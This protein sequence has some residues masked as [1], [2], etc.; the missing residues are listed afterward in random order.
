MS[1]PTI[2]WLTCGVRRQLEAYAQAEG[3]PVE[4]AAG[5]L[6]TD[7]LRALGVPPAPP[8]APEIVTAQYRELPEAVLDHVRAIMS[9]G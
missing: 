5:E 1:I 3:M 7:R 2:A 8:L 4:E 6:V 9:G